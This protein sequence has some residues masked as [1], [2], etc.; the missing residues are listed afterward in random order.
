MADKDKIPK[1]KFYMAFKN[2]IHC[3]DYIAEKLFANS[4]RMGAIP[5]V[6]GA[7]KSDYEAIVPPG[8]F[9]F[10]EDFKTFKE[11]VDYLNYLEKND[12]AYKEHLKWRSMKVKSVSNNLRKYSFCQLCQVLHGINVDNIYNERSDELKSY[13]VMF[14]TY[15]VQTTR[16][17]LEAR[18]FE[19]ETR[20]W[21]RK[22][23]SLDFRWSHNQRIYWNMQK[24][25]SPL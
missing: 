12:L 9:I 18:S 19:T 10:A 21:G 20:L 17:E 22:S 11:L 8:S 1:Y 14:N 23:E 24:P 7:T 2:S 5:V 3:K 13:I 6:Y 4:F 16:N 15:I 25:G